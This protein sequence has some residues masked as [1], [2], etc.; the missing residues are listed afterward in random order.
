MV[1]TVIE[2]AIYLVV[3]LGALAVAGWNVATGQFL[4]MDGLLL[5][6]ICLSGAAVFLGAFALAFRKGE[7][8]DLFGRKRNGQQGGSTQAS[9]TAGGS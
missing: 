9:G 5:T 1:E 3:G 8:G 4:T 2:L 6:L 7:F